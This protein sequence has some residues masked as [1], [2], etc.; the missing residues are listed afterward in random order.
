[1][2][3]PH[4]DVRLDQRRPDA[5]IAYVTISNE[6]KLN[7]LTSALMEEFT[8][9]IGELS[10]DDLLRAVIVTGAGS[11]AFIGGADIHEM[12]Q[13][14]ATTGRAFITRLH[15]CCQ[16][17]RDLPV[18]VIA[19]IHGYALGAGLEIAA[20]CDLR[21][22]SETAHFGMP[23]VKL[24]IPSVIE[25]ALLPSLIG[26]G[27]T[28]Q[29]LLLGETI[30]AAEASKWGLVEMVVLA[31]SLDEQVEHWVTSILAAGPQAVR[32]QKKLIRRWEE[33]PMNAAVLAG[34]DAFE[35]AWKTDEPSRTMQE[36]LARRAK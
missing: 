29:M 31:L 8:A 34:V 3:E 10:R 19:R 5:R 24:G 32:L 2:S 13:L 36:F 16:A 20:A 6:R 27:R 35:A 14:D 15:N 9:A 30:N 7:T 28:R 21:I 26:W 11:R 22:A 1:M 4:I 23:E 33:L 25:A 18:P 12:S 17:L